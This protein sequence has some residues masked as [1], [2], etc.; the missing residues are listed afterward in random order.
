MAQISLKSAVIPFL[1]VI[2]LLIATQVVSYQKPAYKCLEGRGGFTWQGKTDLFSYN[3]FKVSG[4]QLIHDCEP[5]Y[6]FNPETGV[7]CNLLCTRTSGDES[8]DTRN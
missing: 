3:G 7:M 2:V 4:Y 8:R 6:R 1:A 5:K